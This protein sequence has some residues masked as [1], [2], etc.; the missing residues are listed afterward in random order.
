MKKNIVFYGNGNS[1]KSTLVGYIYSKI[2]G[3]DPDNYERSLLKNF[4]LSYEGRRDQLYTWMINR[5]YYEVKMV[6][7]DLTGEPAERR[8]FRERGNTLVTDV[9]HQIALPIAGNETVFT[10]ID[11]PGQDEY[12]DSR[13]EGLHLGEIG[14]FFIEMAEALKPDFSERHFEDY[15]VWP[16]FSGGKPIILLTKIDLDKNFRTKEAYLEACEKVKLFGG[17]DDVTVIPVA[18]V[19][20]ER[21]ALNVLEPAAETPWYEGQPLIE[22]IKRRARQ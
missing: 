1:G 5:D 18:V 11:T 8:V 6:P 21:R 19:V 16:K 7:D 20:P 22:V 12:A 3:V 14:V 13:D 2:Q 9:K 10:L 15:D 4:G 17:Y